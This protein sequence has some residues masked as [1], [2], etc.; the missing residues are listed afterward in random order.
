MA[1]IL[2]D[3]P[4]DPDRLNGGVIGIASALGWHDSGQHVHQCHQLLF[5]QAGCMT[6]ELGNQVYLLPPSRAAWLPAGVPHQVLMRG[7]VAYRSLYFAPQPELPASVQV[8]AVN[9]LLREIIERMAHDHWRCGGMNPATP[10]LRQ[11]HP[12]FIQ[13]GHIT[14]QVFRPTPKDEQQLSVYDGNKMQPQVAWQHFT[15]N[16]LCRSVGIVAVLKSECDNEQLPVVADGEPFPE[17]CYLDFASFDKKTIELK[18]KILSRLSQ[19]RGWL[20]QAA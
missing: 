2:P 1:F 4:F 12:S 19:S 14:S 11:V 15:Q 6:I 16:P 8:V 7:V 5:A 13:A 10:L 20:F 9:P 18:A 17:H 3:H